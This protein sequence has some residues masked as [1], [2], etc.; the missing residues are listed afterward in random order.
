M[1]ITI[2]GTPFE[3]DCYRITFDQ[4]PKT[5][6]SEIPREGFQGTISLKA[7]M[8]EDELHKFFSHFSKTK[9]G[10]EWKS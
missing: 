9:R 1:T 10:A 5:L 4:D 2:D 3:I 7:S 6:S 8:S